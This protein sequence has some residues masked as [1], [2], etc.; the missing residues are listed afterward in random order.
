MRSNA[1]AAVSVH[2]E[3]GTLKEVIVGIQ[4]PEL[5]VI[6]AYYDG[7]RFLTAEA[8]EL[9]ER[10]GGARLVD[11]APDA[12]KRAHEQIDAY[13][14]FLEDRGVIVH[15]SVPPQGAEAT[16]LSEGGSLLFP[17]DPLVVI[18]N[19][20]IE[21]SLK[22]RYRRK[23]R[24]SLRPVIRSLLGRR[25]FS[26]VAAPPPSPNPDDLDTVSAFLE[27]GDVLLNGQEI[28]V[29]ISGCASNF[30]GA[31]WLQ[32]WLGDAYAVYPIELDRNVLHLDCVMSLVRPGLGIICREKIIGDLP[33]ALS[34]FTW[35]DVTPAEVEMMGANGCILD[36]ESLAIVDGMP[37]IAAELRA[38]GQEVFPI[39]YDAPVAAG[40]GLRCSHH[41]LIRE[42]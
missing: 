9:C 14:Q 27:G 12:A 16:Y 30:A 29:G 5:I 25:S 8:K 36:Q 18:G 40:G 26:W 6:P 32:R 34:R 2:H 38:H 21:S 39:A 28:Y 24:Y 10:Y 7:L 33:G 17:R 37:R 11:V 35:I 42:S 22:L 19:T 3:W 31:Q 15:R 4:P 20:I 1:D 13:A 23:E 41:P